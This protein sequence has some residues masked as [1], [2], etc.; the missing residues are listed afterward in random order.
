MAWCAECGWNVEGLRS[1]DEPDVLTRSF[2]RMQRRRGRDVVEAFIAGRRPPLLGRVV[3]MIVAVVVLVMPFL[4]GYAGARLIFSGKGS[5]IILGLPMM[6]GAVWALPWPERHGAE[7]RLKRKRAPA[8]FEA[9]AL[10]ADAMHHRRPRRIYVTTEVNAS[11]SHRGLLGTSLTIGLP[12]W[13]LLDERQ[14]VAVLAHEIG[15]IGNGDPMRTALLGLS[16][17]SLRR[18]YRAAGGQH[19]GRSRPRMGLYVFAPFAIATRFLAVVIAQGLVFASFTSSQYGELRADRSAA[20]QAGSASMVA[21]L[22]RLPIAHQLN[23]EVRAAPV[24]GG[25]AAIRRWL[26]RVPASEW[27]RNAAWSRRDLDGGRATSHP[28]NGVRIDVLE[29]Q[30]AVGS[31][32]A[33]TW[34][35]IDRELESMW[36]PAVCARRGL[37]VVRS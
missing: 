15:H 4:V 25:P 9:V 22:Q 5:L 34:M 31:G 29:R 21:A 23:Q 27:D 16:L 6:I 17:R 13:W 2:R 20:E 26:S 32:L 8:T 30:A 18:W 33:V 24:A 19:R 7:V 14:R 35:A 11:V 37:R 36:V 12:L 1:I 3:A 28:P 10:L